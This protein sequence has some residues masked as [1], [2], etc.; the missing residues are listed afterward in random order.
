MASEK[1]TAIGLRLDVAGKGANMEL[2]FRSRNH[3]LGSYFPTFQERVNSMLPAQSSSEVAAEA[4]ERVKPEAPHFLT[5]EEVSQTLAQVEA[6]AAQQSE[7][8]IQIHS[9]LNEQRVARLLGL[10]D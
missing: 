8:L 7:E 5:N 6:E 2:Q 1:F 3:D 4:I 10:L 9:G